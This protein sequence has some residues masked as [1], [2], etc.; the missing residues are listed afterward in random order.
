VLCDQCAKWRVIPS[1]VVSSLPKKWYCKDNLYDPKRASCDAL[2]QTDKQVA[3]ERKK[4]KKRKQRL[5]MEAAAAEAGESKH[6]GTL[7]GTQIEKVDRSRSPRPTDVQE[8]GAKPNRE[9]PVPLCQA[10]ECVDDAQ[11]RLEK[12]ASSV[13]RKKGRPSETKQE[14][15]S[16]P[17]EPVPEIVVRRGRGRPRR[18]GGINKE[19][20]SARTDDADNLEWVQCELC[21]KWRKL[22]PHISADMLPD[23]WYCTMNTWSGNATCEAPED[24]ADGLQDVGVFG[25]SG[26]ITGKLSY[27]NLIFG[28]TG[29]K[30]NRPVSERTRAAESIFGVVSEDDDSTP[31][32]KYANSSAF[33]SRSKHAEEEPPLSVFELMNYSNLWAELRA[34][35]GMGGNGVIVKPNMSAFTFDTLPIEVKQPVKDLILEVLGERTLTGED[36]MLGSQNGN[37]ENLSVACLNARPYC[38]INVVVTALCEL[39]REGILECLREANATWTVADWTPRYRRPSHALLPQTPEEVQSASSLMRMGSR[40]MKIAKPWKRM[41]T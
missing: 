40:C 41:H 33:V 12:K 39:V 24:K 22:P 29:R 34:N 7:D 35:G 38:T 9:S 30:P 6:L 36:V 13:I 3:K 14:G 2:E 16:P 37:W 31:I 18:N 28:N 8:E 27:R 21:D 15:E 17:T 26:S 20:S 11:P 4:M 19:T 5:L 1:N 25:G 23:I 10:V 32:V